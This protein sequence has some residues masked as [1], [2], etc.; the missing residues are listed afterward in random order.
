M[1]TPAIIAVSV[2]VE[3]SDTQPAPSPSIAERTSIQLAT[4]FPKI[5]PITT[6][7]PCLTFMAPELTKLTTIT[8]VADDE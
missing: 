3:I 4:A 8:E 5:A 7:I 2:E 1:P 6:L